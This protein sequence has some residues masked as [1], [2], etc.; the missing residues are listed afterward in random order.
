MVLL[1]VLK[2][3][4]VVRVI[5]FTT[6]NTKLSHIFI[7]LEISSLPFVALLPYGVGFI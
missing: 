1:Y 5:K 4:L 6:E 2:N 7:T 3:H